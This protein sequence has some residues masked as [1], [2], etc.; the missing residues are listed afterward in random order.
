ME[1]F[2]ARLVEKTH[3]LPGAQH[4]FL[5][6]LCAPEGEATRSLLQERVDRSPALVQER[7]L[8]MLGSL[9][10]RRFFQGYSELLV[11]DAMHGAGWLTQR[12]VPP[13]PRFE[14]GREGRSPLLVSVLATLQNLRPGGEAHNRSRLQHALSRVVASHR[15][16][17]LIRRWL[18][19]DLDPAP[20]RR[21]IELWLGRVAAG[22]WEGRYA[23]YEDEVLSLE[24]SLTGE[25][26]SE[27]QSPL[28]DMI[29][30][31]YA[32]RTMEAIEPRIV[33][34][35]DAHRLSEHGRTP[36]LV[37]CATDARWLINESYILDFLYGRPSRVGAETGWEIEV[38]ALAGGACV[39]R[40]PV[41]RGVAGL[42]LAQRSANGEMGF[43]GWLNPWCPGRPEPEDLHFPVVSPVPGRSNDAV[44]LL[45]RFG[46]RS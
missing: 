46:G 7:A 26:C 42:V 27:G 1:L 32:H 10:N 17:V 6:Q 11:L 40:D 28:A 31:F 13:Q 38:P 36:L 22:Q 29:G 2:P 37:V 23:T 30:P 9:D 3:R 33:R 45:R 43:R 25:R 21:A 16:V 24:F 15:F 44:A 14:V 12:V 20:V 4:S 41:Y 5:K 34:E 35:L 8:T 39:F 19:T 18:P